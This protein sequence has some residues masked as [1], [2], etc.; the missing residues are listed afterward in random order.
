MSPDGSSVHALVPFKVVNVKGFTLPQTG[1]YSML[2]Y[3]SVG[4]LV[5][6]GAA[7]LIVL[8]CRRR[9]AKRNRR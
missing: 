6:A 1:S 7:M 5:M 3:T 4:I 8:L 9:P 2:I